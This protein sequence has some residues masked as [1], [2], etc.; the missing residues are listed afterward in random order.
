[1]DTYRKYNIF[2]NTTDLYICNKEGVMYYEEFDKNENNENNEFV[3]AEYED[4]NSGN[5]SSEGGNRKPPKKSGKGPIIALIV[6]IVVIGL[7]IC[8]VGGYFL[9]SNVGEVKDNIISQQ[10]T[11][12]EQD[13]GSTKTGNDSS[14]KY[15][16]VDVSGVVEDAMPSVVAITSTTFVESSSNDIYDFYFGNGYGNSNSGKQKQEQKAAGSGFIVDQNNDE[17]LIV[18]NNHVVE[19]ADKLAIQFYGQKNKETVSGVIKGTNE[20]KDVAVVAVKMKDIPEKIKSGIKKATLGDSNQVKVG[21]GAIAIGNALG[22]GQS[23]TAGVISAVNRD[24]EIENKKMTL[25]QTD[26]PINGG[27]SGGALLNQNGEVIGINVAKYS[28]SG[29]S[30]SVEGMGFAIPISSVKD[31]IKKLEKQQ[32]RTKQSESEQ[33]YLGIVGTTVDEQTSQTYSTP[34]GV[35]VREV[36]KDGAADKAGIQQTDVITELDGKT[37]ESMDD[38]TEALEY[39]KAGETVKVKVS[40]RSGAKYKSK[41]VK[42]T[43]GKKPE[44]SSSDSNNNNNSNN[45][46]DEYYS[47]GDDE[48]SGDSFFSFPW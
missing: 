3:D 11:T 5:K 39:Y 4:I 9:L 43:L 34:K 18:T 27:N 21:N 35:F 2:Q 32:S 47:Y 8:G 33:G 26:A 37:I 29:S 23:V 24:V 28:S 48:D 12:A 42:V 45:N 17:L 44:N 14:N 40:Y 10:E 31:E 22:F 30:G 19:D 13:I 25:I 16:V 7:G 41:T 6:A 38:L 20:A 1:M 36:I 46:G 15:S